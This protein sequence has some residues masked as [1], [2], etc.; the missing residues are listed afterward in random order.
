MSP[1]LR[2]SQWPLHR[3]AIYATHSHVPGNEDVSKITKQR[4]CQK[5]LPYP[6]L[7]NNSTLPRYIIRSHN[8]SRHPML[9]SLGLSSFHRHAPLPSSLPMC[10]FIIKYGQSCHVEAAQTDSVTTQLTTMCTVSQISHRLL[11]IN[12]PYIVV[13]SLGGGCRIFVDIT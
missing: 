2:L 6:P 7:P 8:A 1:S 10:C 12:P 5:M 9:A 4:S 13:I 3:I 11:I